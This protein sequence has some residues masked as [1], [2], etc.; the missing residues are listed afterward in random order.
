M[1]STIALLVAATPAPAAV[2]TGPF[3]ALTANYH[4][5]TGQY[6]IRSGW[7]TA[8]WQTGRLVRAGE[9]AKIDQWRARGLTFDSVEA[10]RAKAARGVNV[11]A[12]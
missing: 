4:V 5:K 10:A 6:C 7:R 8:T 3:D 9:C 11:A 12:R 1:F 2:P